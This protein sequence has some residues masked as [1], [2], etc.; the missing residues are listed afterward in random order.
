MGINDNSFW[1]ESENVNVHGKDTLK[2][3]LH[4]KANL[5]RE[6]LDIYR[7]WSCEKLDYFY[8]TRIFRMVF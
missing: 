4:F 1:T 8:Q 7:K 2:V 3:Y 5:D 6:S